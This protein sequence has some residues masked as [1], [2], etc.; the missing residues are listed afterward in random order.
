MTTYQR[1]A[2]ADVL[3]EIKPLLSMHWREIAHY[4][5]VPLDPDYDFYLRAQTIRVYTA[6]DQGALIGY[7]IFFVAPNKHYM[8]SVQAVQDIL[9]IL[10]Q[11]RGKTVGPRLIAFCDEQ[12]KSEGVQAV[13][14]HVKA[15]HDF[16]PLLHRMGYEVVDVIHAKR[17]DRE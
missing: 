2:V 7:G 11:Y 5:D 15:A 3:N 4:Q 14:H 17:L 1:E 16:G 13:Y 8:G 12:L 6:R 9:F 10:P